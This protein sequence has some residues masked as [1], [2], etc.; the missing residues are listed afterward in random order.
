MSAAHIWRFAAQGLS[1]RRRPVSD[2]DG[3][4]ARQDL[5]RPVGTAPRLSGS[6]LP[7]GLLPLPAGFESAATT[8]AARQLFDVLASRH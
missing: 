7:S 4:Y 5:P 1:R 3:W 8:S 6:P 2:A